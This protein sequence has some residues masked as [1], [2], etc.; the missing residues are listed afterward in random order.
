MRTVAAW[1]GALACGVAL[2][3]AAGEW[4]SGRVVNVHDGDT[5]TIATL[6]A[7]V[8]Q[9][10]FYGVDAPER[11]TEDW[12]AQ[13]HAAAATRFVRGM[14]L[15]RPVSVRLTGERTYGREV[16]EVFVDGRSVSRELLRAG[17]G[18]W[19]ARYAR[20]DRDLQSLE[21]AARSARR[22]LWQNAEALAPWQHR[23]R[24]RPRPRR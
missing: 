2:P 24:H 23:A 19:N 7:R 20:D 5:A 17:L 8:L 10:R 13:A 16:G 6:D 4:V 11:A 14:L 1:L 12:P 18:W 21:Q 9:V 3:L 15:E 22:G